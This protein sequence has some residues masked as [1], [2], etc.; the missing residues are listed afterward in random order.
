MEK[1][2]PERNSRAGEVKTMSDELIHLRNN[3][4]SSDFWGPACLKKEIRDTK[5]ELVCDITQVTC[6]KC[7]SGER[8]GH[9]NKGRYR[10]GIATKKQ[11]TYVRERID[12][13]NGYFVTSKSY[14][15]TYSF[16]AK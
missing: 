6:P 11:K 5:Y 14:D 10:R 8:V 15:N 4:I 2:F 1:Y 13:G 9:R 3:A 16:G 12:P 7:I